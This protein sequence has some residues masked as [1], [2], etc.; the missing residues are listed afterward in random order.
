MSNFL[1]DE[2]ELDKFENEDQFDDYNEFDDDEDEFDDEDI[3]EEYENNEDYKDEAWQEKHYEKIECRV[4]KLKADAIKVEGTEDYYQV[5]LSLLRAENESVRKNRHY[6]VM[7]LDDSGYVLAVYI[8]SINPENLLKISPKAMYKIA[9][10]VEATKVIV[11]FNV[12]N[13]ENLIPKGR[14]IEFFN[15]TF[16]ITGFLEI[17]VLDTMVIGEHGFHS[18]REDGYLKYYRE[19]ESFK[20]VADVRDLLEKQKK[21]F[22]RRH[23]EKRAIQADLGARKNTAIAMLV[24]GEDV[25]KIMHYTGLSMQEIE[26]LIKNL[27]K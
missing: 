26:I 25:D 7:A 15:K 8:F 22:A 24:A 2:N 9:I 11:A 6:W 4:L 14:D 19:D 3:F 27:K 5:F 21:R 13:G 17:E 16:N 1:D 23:A 10:L 18:D 12:P 20:L